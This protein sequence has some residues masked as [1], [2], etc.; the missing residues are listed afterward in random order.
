MDSIA[1]GRQVEDLDFR[2]FHKNGELR[3]LR[4][5]G[6]L[7]F[8][9]NGHPV[10]FSGTMQDITESKL[11]EIKIHQ[12][13]NQLRALRKIDQAINLSFNMRATLATVIEQALLQLQVD[14][15]DVLILNPEEQRLTYVAGKGFRTSTIKTTQPSLGD[16]YAGRV[17]RERRLIKIENLM[18]HPAGDLPSHRFGGGRFRGLL[19]RASDHHGQGQGCAGD[20]SSYAFATLSRVAGV[21]RSS[22]RAGRHC[23]RQ[24][25]VI[26]RF[27]NEQPGIDASLRSHHRGLVSRAGPARQGNRRAYPPRNPEDITTGSTD[28]LIP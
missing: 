19:W 9:P 12:Q 17:A 27:A 1:A 24:R 8:D 11:A 21:S 14:A 2:I 6:A 10:R 28:G 16:S 23:S 22:G 26:R 18:D 20:I 25:K 5:N 7:I 13:I 4:S 3:Y 15:A